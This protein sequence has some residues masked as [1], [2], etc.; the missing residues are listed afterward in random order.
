MCSHVGVEALDVHHP[1]VEQQVVVQGLQARVHGMF[2]V[3]MIGTEA[4]A[5]LGYT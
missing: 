3:V 5:R 4:V 2:S 1:L